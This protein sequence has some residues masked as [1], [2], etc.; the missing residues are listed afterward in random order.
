LGGTRI[1]KRSRRPASR[2]R[3]SATSPVVGSAATDLDA[4]QAILA[5]VEPEDWYGVRQALVFGVGVPIV[6]EYVERRRAKWRLLTEEN[7]RRRPRGRFRTGHAD[8]RA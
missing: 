4:Y 2:A 5:A 8:R 3:R 1:A 6:P 7:E